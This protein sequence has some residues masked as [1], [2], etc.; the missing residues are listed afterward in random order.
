MR[1]GRRAPRL[2][3]RR[4]LCRTRHSTGRSPTEHLPRMRR[5]YL[6]RGP[7]S[8]IVLTKARVAQAREPFA[9]TPIDL[10]AAARRRL[11]LVSQSNRDCPEWLAPN[12]K[13]K[14]G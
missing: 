2:H 9:L 14:M 7:C 13:A 5:T 3:T 1:D 11:L 10:A 8:A 4:W 6:L 12:F